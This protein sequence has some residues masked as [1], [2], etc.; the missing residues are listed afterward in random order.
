[1]TNPRSGL[2]SLPTR[3]VTLVLGEL[4]NLTLL[5]DQ[6]RHNVNQRQRQ[7]QKPLLLE[8]VTAKY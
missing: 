7:L 4:L 3:F 5:P 6:H 2:K 1:M 8:A